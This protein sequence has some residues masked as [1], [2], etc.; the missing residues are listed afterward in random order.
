MLDCA[1]PSPL[2]GTDLQI[3]LCAC[4]THSHLGRAAGSWGVPGTAAL[5][6]KGSSSRARS[7][8]RAGSRSQLWAQPLLRT[9]GC[10]PGVPAPHRCQPHTGDCTAL[11]RLCCPHTLLSLWLLCWVSFLACAS[12]V[13][14]VSC[15]SHCLIS[16]FN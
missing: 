2:Q 8:S 15:L 9:W 6:H 14:A 12:F 1:L 10:Q 16:L 4:S 7:P 13:S 3:S 11:G 5:A